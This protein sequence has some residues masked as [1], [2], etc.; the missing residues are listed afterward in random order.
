MRRNM[1]NYLVKTAKMLHVYA[2][3]SHIP[4]ELEIF[5]RMQ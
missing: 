1:H 5:M 4:A 3:S 2:V